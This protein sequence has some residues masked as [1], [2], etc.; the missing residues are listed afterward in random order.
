MLIVCGVCFEIVHFINH[1]LSSSLLL[2]CVGRLCFLSVAIP[3]M[4][5]LLFCEFEQFASPWNIKQH[6]RAEV[7]VGVI[8]PRPLVLVCS[9]E[10]LL[11][12]V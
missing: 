12:Q 4:R 6:C 3:D 8:S 9:Y 11:G 1:A 2:G 7:W 5:I 10:N